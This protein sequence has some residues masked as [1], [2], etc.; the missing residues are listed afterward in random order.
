M[1]PQE[2]HIPVTRTARYY[3]LGEP[4]PHLKRVWFVLHG[5]GQLA[6]YFIR[7]FDVV[8]DSTTL[9]IAPEALS[10]F[11]ND[12]VNGRV[13]ATW[14]TKEDRR[15]E[16]NDYL[17][18]LDQLYTRIRKDIG[19]D[20][21][22]VLL[23]FSQGTAT[24]WRWLKQGTLNPDHFINWAGNVPQEM[25]ET[26]AERLRGVQLYTAVGTQDKYISPEL[27][28]LLVD[29]LRNLAP[30]LVDLRFPG[31]HRMDRP[32]LRKIAKKIVESA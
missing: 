14:M 10:R 23:G 30:D 11:Y 7:H 20:V 13:G 19:K 8:H 22:K 24:A 28:D 16:I 5:Y 27:A 32:T 31:E 15:N 6:S 3:Q 29:G 9:V 21:E 25:N 12:G 1:E 4:G 26:W 18:Y 2:Q 17:N